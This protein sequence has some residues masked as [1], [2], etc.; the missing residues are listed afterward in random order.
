MVKFALNKG[1]SK[2]RPDAPVSRVQVL[3]LASPL[4]PLAAVGVLEH[5][6]FER[7]ARAFRT[8]RSEVVPL[9]TWP[10]HVSHDSTDGWFC[11]DS[12]EACATTMRH[13]ETERVQSTR[14]PKVCHSL[15]R[16]S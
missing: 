12:I 9:K 8:R 15:S 16:R 14:R 11:V 4:A 3:S 5:G 13:D 1:T 2:G 7:T 10:R 6:R